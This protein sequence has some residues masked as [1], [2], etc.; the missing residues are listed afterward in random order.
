MGKSRKP[1][2]KGS[3][4][5]V[6]SWLATVIFPQNR[7]HRG[8]PTT[9]AVVS[10]AVLLTAAFVLPRASLW[11]ETDAIPAPTSRMVRR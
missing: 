5:A 2:L 11:V 8:L 6:A 1:P 10:L 3:I 4:I 9:V 7:V